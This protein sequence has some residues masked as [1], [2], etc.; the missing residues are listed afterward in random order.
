MLF[1][2]WS[3]GQLK[4]AGGETVAAFILLRPTSPTLEH[5]GGADCL[6]C[7]RAGEEQAGIG[8]SCLRL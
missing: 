7:R 1:G 3:P 8:Q 5:D 2:V 6:G 4:S